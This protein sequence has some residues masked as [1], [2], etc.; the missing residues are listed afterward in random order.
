M[1]IRIGTSGWQYTDWRDV[2]YPRGL[3]RRQWL[4]RYTEWFSTVE[5]NN[6]FY[7]LPSYEQFARWCERMPVGFQMAVKGSRF[8]THVKRMRDPKEPVERLM[9]AVAG[10]GERLGPI[11]LQ[12]PPTQQ[13]DLDRLDRCLRCFPAHVRVAVE[14]RHA[15]WWVPETRE[16]LTERGAALCWS[17]RLGRPQTPLWRT[18]GWGY[19]RFHQGRAK[20][21][22]SYGDAALRSWLGRIE[23][24]WDPA[25]DVYAYFN[26]DPGGAAVRNAVRLG[27]L[28]GRAG[29][30]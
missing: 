1:P 27:M 14:P 16:M 10:L 2:L 26:N 23:A 6:A 20:P 5:S 30:T 8:L 18:A 22:P 13:A 21:L 4:E 24:A 12:L 11:L 29:R 17:D 9:G 7:R 3:P 25:Q 28:A 15:S 19:V